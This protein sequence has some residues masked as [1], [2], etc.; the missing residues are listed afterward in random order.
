MRIVMSVLV[1]L[2]AL[3]LGLSVYAQDAQPAAQGSIMCDSDLLLNLYI[4]NRFAGFDQF[5]TRLSESGVDPATIV[6]LSQFNRGQ[7]DPLFQGAETMPAAPTAGTE[8]TR[9]GMFDLTEDQVNQVVDILALDEA[10][11]QTE[12]RNRVPMAEGAAPVT[13]LVPG[14]VAG[15]APE[16][17]QLRTSLNRFWT[18]LAIEDFSS[19]MMLGMNQGAT[20]AAEG[21]TGETGAATA[22]TMAITLTGLEEV[23]GPG[24][25][26]GTGTANVEVRPDTNEVCWDITVQNLTL[27]GTAAHIH[28]GGVGVAGGPVVTLTAP[29]DSGAS[30]GCAAVDAALAADLV[31]NPANYYVNVHTSDFPDGAVRG[32]LGM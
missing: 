15:E 2:F 14:A 22:T 12:F 6:D 9:F 13:D 16:C 28:E 7:F 31:A 5:Q 3:V 4:A 30:S 11:F 18:A 10:T 20:G 23:P 26:D 24:D 17:V 29:D 8:T 21:E 19:G 25:E 32:Q 27:P 1:V